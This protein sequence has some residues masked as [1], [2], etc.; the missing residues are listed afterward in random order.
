MGGA[1]YKLLETSLIHNEIRQLSSNAAML[2]SLLKLDP[3]FL[4]HRILMNPHMLVQLIDFQQEKTKENGNFSS[5]ILSHLKKEN[6]YIKKQGILHIK[7]IKLYMLFPLNS[8]DNKYLLISNDLTS[9]NRV[10][11]RLGQIILL[12]S[13][14][15]VVL[16]VFLLNFFLKNTIVTPLKNIAAD[17]KEIKQGEKQYIRGKYSFEFS[18]LVKIF[19]E[20]LD[21]IGQQKRQLSDKIEELHDLNHLITEYHKEMINFEKLISIGELSAGIAHEI[22]NPLNNIQGYLTLLKRNHAISNNIELIDYLER[23]ASDINRID[24]IIKG[25][26]DYSRKDPSVTV[27]ASLPVVIDQ[28]LNLAQLRLKGLEIE[29]AKLYPQDIDCMVSIDI[30][31]F[32]QVF[33]NLI[34]NAIDSIGEKGKGRVEIDIK[35]VTSLPQGQEKFFIEVLKRRATAYVIL[36]IRDNGSGISQKDLPHVFDPFFTTKEAGKG[37][38]LG[39]PVSLQ[40]IKEMGGTIHIESEM[41]KGS[42]VQI[43]L[44]YDDREIS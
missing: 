25:I 8:F 1:T 30:H 15:T 27:T 36:S 11:G 33:L 26:L 7:Y 17:I 38:G 37:T 44:P 29:I 41:G 23:I 4:K 9:L 35:R 18:Y 34:N 14:I 32:Q 3:T 24:L 10:L 21:E 22:G 19:N 13:V 6:V 31:K 20:L 42:L 2:E 39:L 16:I 5:S 40:L 28:T 43:I 12:I